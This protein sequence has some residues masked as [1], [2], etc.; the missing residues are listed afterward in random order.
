[1]FFFKDT[2]TPSH[3]LHQQ[4]SKKMIYLLNRGTKVR[5]LSDNHLILEDI[6]DWNWK[7]AK[8]MND[9]CKYQ[10][11]FD[12]HSSYVANT[13]DIHGLVVS[14][15]ILDNSK[16]WVVFHFLTCIL[17]CITFLMWAQSMYMNA[18]QPVAHTEF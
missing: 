11:F 17:T 2:T 18:S 15:S 9:I 13:D 7:D 16:Y 12:V 1:M 14:V 4:I 3:Y 8:K 10:L 5:K 6:D